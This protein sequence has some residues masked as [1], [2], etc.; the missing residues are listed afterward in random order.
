MTAPTGSG[1]GDEIRKVMRMLP[2]GVAM[3]TCWL[4]ERP[5]GLTINTFNSISI[6][7][8]RV[9]VT[10]SRHTASYEA[11]EKS[12]HFG[13]SLLTESQIDI[14]RFGSA[15]GEPKFL[16]EFTA[17]RLRGSGPAAAATKDGRTLNAVGPELSPMV[18]N[19]HNHLDCA[20]QQIVYGGDH[21][22]IIGEVRSVR[23]GSDHGV[24][25]LLYFDARYYALGKRY[26]TDG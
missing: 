3:V 22:L 23:G 4:E 8:P 9:L 10:L 14:A 20:V 15:S 5:W 2:N 17:D 12:S 11:I 7:P 16:E 21:G 19:A 6:Y 18:E 25:P 13:I 26:E 24:S 1:S